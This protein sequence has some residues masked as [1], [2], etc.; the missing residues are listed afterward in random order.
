MGQCVG[1][2]FRVRSRAREGARPT[3]QVRVRE[4]AN[5]CVHD[6]EDRVL[7]WGLGEIDA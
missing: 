6:C 5:Q 1:D 7:F 3:G 4:R 2:A